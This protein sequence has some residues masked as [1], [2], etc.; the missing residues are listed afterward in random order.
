MTP[1]VY[2]QAS[3]YAAKLDPPSLLRRL[4]RGASPAPVFDRWLD[5][6]RLA[7]PG[8]LERTCDLVASIAEP[9]IMEQWKRLAEPEADRVRRADYGGLALVFAEAAGR[10]AVWKNALEGWNMVESQ[11]VLEWMAQ[12]EAKGK[13]EG[14]AEGE[15]KDRVSALLRLLELR[16][17]PAVPA[18]LE[19]TIRTTT[20]LEV[21]LRWFDAAAIA[22]SLDDFR[23]VIQPASRNGT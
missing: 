11:Q 19:T 22:D 3:R 5:T 17:P 14:L 21:L 13:A 16:F 12:G 15:V 6:R 7:F 9:R 10:L 20:D 23:R 8:N 4:L 1:N 18:D 2:D